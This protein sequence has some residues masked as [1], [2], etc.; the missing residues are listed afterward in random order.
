VK[1]DWYAVRDVRREFRLTNAEAAVLIEI[2]GVAASES[3]RQRTWTGTITELANELHLARRNVRGAI[4]RLQAMGLLSAEVPF[5]NSSRGTFGV[6]IWDWLVVAKDGD[7]DPE[8][9]KVDGLA[10]AA[11]SAR[12]YRERFVDPPSIPLR[13]DRREVPREVP[14][15]EGSPIGASRDRDLARPDSFTHESD[16]DLDGE[17]QR[18]LDERPLT[19]PEQQLEKLD[20]SDPT[21]WVKFAHL[22]KEIVQRRRRTESGGVFSAGSS[23]ANRSSLDAGASA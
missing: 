11:C 1:F 19:E 14:D 8:S 20:P 4:D 2:V 16:D 13:S 18:W 10:A 5:G 12:A 6:P 9:A 3:F 15:H 17:Y 21:Y 7:F 22:R 23:H